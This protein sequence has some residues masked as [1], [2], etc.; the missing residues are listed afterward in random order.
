MALK[1]EIWIGLFRGLAFATRLMAL[2]LYDM[3]LTLCCTHDDDET[4]QN[5]LTI[6]VQISRQNVLESGR[7]EAGAL[8]FKGTWH[9]KRVLRSLEFLGS[10]SLDFPFRYRFRRDGPRWVDAVHLCTSPYLL[11]PVAEYPSRLSFHGPL[12]W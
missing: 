10:L 4:E 3:I 5:S 1:K 6:H 9:G 8:L 12:S 2:E 7:N 11:A